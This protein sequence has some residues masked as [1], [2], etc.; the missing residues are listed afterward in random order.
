[1]NM[2]MSVS[3]LGI[4]RKRGSNA[5]LSNIVSPD[6]NEPVTGIPTRYNNNKSIISG[7]LYKLGRQGKWQRR[8]FESDGECLSYFKSE[9]RKDLLAQLDLLHVGSVAMDDT[10][11]ADCSFIID[12]AGRKYHLCAES[13]DHAMDWVISMNRVRE[14]RM[15]IGNLKLIHPLQEDDITPRVVMVAKRKRAKGL[16]IEDFNEDINSIGHIDGENVNNITGVTFSEASSPGSGT[17]SVDSSNIN[18][19]QEALAAARQPSNRRQ[20]AL[21]RWRKRRPSYQNWMRRLSRW[22]KRLTSVRFVIREDFQHLGNFGKRSSESTTKSPLV[23][24]TTLIPQVQNDGESTM[25]SPSAKGGSEA[26]LD[27]TSQCPHFADL[28]PEVRGSLNFEQIHIAGQNL[29]QISKRNATRS[30]TPKS[31]ANDEAYAAFEQKTKVSTP[32][33]G[34]ASQSRILR[35]KME[36]ASSHENSANGDVDSSSGQDSSSTI[37]EEARASGVV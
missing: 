20:R 27:P 11:P 35:E 15:E 13:K 31:Q 21:L 14:A 17:E 25:W 3:K 5:Q 23:H 7:Y 9:K 33:C 19:E 36:E 18:S 4:G 29:N 1:M 32:K 28:D 8:W 22:A 24:T 16:G 37:D 6:E 2:K 34:M 30:E 26:A 10:D 12:V